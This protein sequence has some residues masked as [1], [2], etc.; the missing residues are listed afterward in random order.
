[1]SIGSV[2]QY[3]VISYTQ[4]LWAEKRLG[5]PVICDLSNHGS[6]LPFFLAC[7]TQTTISKSVRTDVNV[8]SS[9]Q[10]GP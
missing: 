9:S 4:H 1:M 2:F 8:N 10:T 7:H 3:K 5:T 6:G